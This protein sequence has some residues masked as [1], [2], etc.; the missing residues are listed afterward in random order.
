MFTY[1]GEI[2]HSTRRDN[3]KM[4]LDLE[5]AAELSP[6]SIQDYEAAVDLS[7]SVSSLT[8]DCPTDGGLLRA[9]TSRVE[10]SKAMASI[11]SCNIDSEDETLF[12]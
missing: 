12:G 9:L 6:L 3:H 2:A 4:E 5:P 10:V 11:G 8:L 7:A 1:D